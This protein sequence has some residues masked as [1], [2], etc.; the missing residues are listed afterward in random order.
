MAVMEL[1]LRELNRFADEPLEGSVSVENEE[2]ETEDDLL[3]VKEEHILDTNFDNLHLLVDAA[4][5]DMER[6]SS[7]VEIERELE[8]DYSALDL[9]VPLY[10]VVQ[11]DQKAVVENVSVLAGLKLVDG[12]EY[13][14]VEDSERVE[15]DHPFDRIVVHTRLLEVHVDLYQPS[16]SLSLHNL[17]L[18]RI[19]LE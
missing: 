19:L 7:V 13:Q 10:M 9:G 11:N 16:Y 12:S 17:E 14:F 2:V 5:T 15:V 6:H 8:R 1:Q 4:G 3:D 18:L